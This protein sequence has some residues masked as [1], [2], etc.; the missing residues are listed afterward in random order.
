MNA[1]FNAT[2]ELGLASQ[3]TTFTASD[4]SRTFKPAGTGT[5]TGTDH[6]WGSHQFIMGGGVAGGDFYGTYP[7]LELGGSD[8]ADA[9]S[10]A[11][12]RWIPTTSVD[13]Y[14]STLA[15]W[16]GLPMSELA[17]VFPNLSNFG[18]PH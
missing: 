4:F 12:G 2:Q 8:D 15:L 14:A 10:T 16:Y 18:N 7:D 6:A 1:F 13:Q 5:A 11:R 3:V 17:V 9:G